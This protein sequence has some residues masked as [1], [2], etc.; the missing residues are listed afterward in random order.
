MN[1][2]GRRGGKST[3][4]AGKSAP[5]PRFP[6]QD[7]MKVQ[8]NLVNLEGRVRWRNQDAFRA[9]SSARNIKA[10]IS[11]GNYAGAQALADKRVARI[12]PAQRALDRYKRMAA[13]AGY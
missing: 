10:G 2:G 3:A 5:A 11:R 7:A 13:Q 4:P 1:P 9:E 6:V 12:K 8:R